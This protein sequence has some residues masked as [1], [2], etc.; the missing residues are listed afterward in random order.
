MRNVACK[1]FDDN[2]MCKK[3]YG[4]YL[5]NEFNICYKD[6]CERD[7]NGKCIKCT[8][9]DDTVL[10]NGECSRNDYCKEVDE[11]GYC[12]RCKKKDILS[13]NTVIV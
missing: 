4:N 5:L 7:D 12:I 10:S 11:K 2:G 8:D 13:M 6:S 3:C 1:S 9:S